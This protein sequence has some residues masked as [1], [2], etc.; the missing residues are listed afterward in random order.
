[1]LPYPVKYSSLSLYNLWFRR[2]VSLGKSE[3][4]TKSLKGKGKR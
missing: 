3:R 4:K 1:M 2:R